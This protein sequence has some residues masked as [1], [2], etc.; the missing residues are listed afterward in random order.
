[1]LRHDSCIG[2]AVEIKDE[3]KKSLFLIVVASLLATACAKHSSTSANAEAKEYFDAW[4]QVNYPD[5]KPTPLGAYVLEDVEGDGKLL[6]DSEN[7]KYI[8]VEVTASALDGTISNTT[9]ESVAKQLGTYSETDFYGPTIWTRTGDILYAGVD[10]AVSTMRVGGRKKTIIPG[11]LFTSNRY[12]TPQEYVDNVTGANAIYDIEVVEAFDDLVKWEIDSIGR[13]LAANYS[14]VTVADSVKFGYYYIQE[15]APTDTASFPNDTTFYINYI[16]RLLNG[17]VFD[18]NIADTAKMYGLY[19]SSSTY[20]P[21]L[22]NYSS[23]KYEEITMGTDG[24][25]LIDG[26]SYALWKMKSYEKGRCIFYSTLGYSATGSGNKIPAYSP[27]IF[28]IEI[29]GKP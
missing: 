25:S 2:T 28:D 8:R 20:S 17:K 1:M 15:K 6:G 5:L 24:G 26:F 19:N 4:I 3:M 22:I 18:T 13:Y 7:S 9:R 12:D 16:G 11:W 14:D 23:D 21:Q 10:E 29:V 27:L